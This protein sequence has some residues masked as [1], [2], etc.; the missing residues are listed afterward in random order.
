MCDVCQYLK[1]CNAVWIVS[2]IHRAVNDQTASVL[3]GE[4]FR[5]QLLMDGH[6]GSVTFI[7]SKT[8]IVNPPEIIR[9][10]DSVE[11]IVCSSLSMYVV[12]I[13]LG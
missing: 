5:R 11:I 4:R 1:N 10:L 9:F 7:C 2:S 3:L 8:D 6:Y 12:I 13:C